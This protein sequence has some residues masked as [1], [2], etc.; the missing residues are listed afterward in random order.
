MAAPQEC[1]KEGRLGIGPVGRSAAAGA[2]AGRRLGPLRGG[3]LRGG[4]AGSLACDLKT[5]LTAAEYSELAFCL[6]SRRLL[7][8]GDQH[9]RHSRRK[10][11]GTVILSS[12]C[13]A[14]TVDNNQ[15]LLRGAAHHSG[16]Q[17]RGS[18]L[19]RIDLRQRRRLAHDQGP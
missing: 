3:G 9:Q 5:A 13:H 18:R 11:S 12:P 10:E 2:L 16:K 4:H 7:A 8:H 1:L 15:A 14:C 6:V 19:C 17:K